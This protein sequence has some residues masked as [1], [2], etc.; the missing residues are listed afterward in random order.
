MSFSLR[1]EVTWVGCVVPDDPGAGQGDSRTPEAGGAPKAHAGNPSTPETETG[2]PE[3]D[4]GIAVCKMSSSQVLILLST[5]FKGFW[6]YFWLIIM[7]K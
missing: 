6:L 1:K 5:F 4:P 2:D 3:A 7:V